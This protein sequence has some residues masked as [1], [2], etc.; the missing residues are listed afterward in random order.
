MARIK[1]RHNPVS[2]TTAS[3]MLSFAPITSRSNAAR[4]NLAF[5]TGIV[6]RYSRR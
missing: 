3:P 2:G 4:R 6:N 1:S 5:V